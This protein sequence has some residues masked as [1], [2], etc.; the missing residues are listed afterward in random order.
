MS[1]TAANLL[2]GLIGAIIGAIVGGILSLVGSLVV[3]R[4]ERRAALRHQLYLLAADIVPRMDEIPRPQLNDGHDETAKQLD[5][6]SRLGAIAGRDERRLT[7]EALQQW[8]K[9]RNAT[10]RQDLPD[11]TAHLVNA[12]N[13]LDELLGA[14]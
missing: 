11:V 12:S 5:T 1:D 9:A 2:S 4:R 3:N 6:M 8:L 14:C 10:A 7:A 13:A